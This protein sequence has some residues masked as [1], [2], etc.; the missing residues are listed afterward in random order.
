[1]EKGLK[2]RRRERQEWTVTIKVTIKEDILEEFGI[3]TKPM[4]E[5]P[6][7]N[8]EIQTESMKCWVPTPDYKLVPFYEF[9]DQEEPITR[10]DSDS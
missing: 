3:E 4:L 1:M 2:R 9:S 10:S 5:K 8:K 6:L 7:E